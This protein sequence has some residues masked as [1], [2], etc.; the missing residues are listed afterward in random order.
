MS[1][2]SSLAKISLL[3]AVLA[4][5]T[6]LPSAQPLG[7]N[8]Q[9]V[10][11]ACYAAYR[12]TRLTQVRAI[13]SALESQGYEVRASDVE[14]G[15]VSAER[16]RRQ[17]GLGATRL[18]RSGGMG[19]FGSRR[20]GVA[21]G[22]GFGDPFDVFRSDPYSIERVSVSADGQRY[23]AVRSM[24]VVSPDGFIIDARQ[25]SPEPFCQQTHAAIEQAL[26][27]SGGTP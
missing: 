5:C 12:G 22:Y 1:F 3:G 8:E 11:E 25:A 20:R 16:T 9:A 4:G 7:I 19:W 24:T 6:S 23:L 13:A 2:I 21:L 17:P 18:W 27:S 10:P 15:L 26:T 14:L